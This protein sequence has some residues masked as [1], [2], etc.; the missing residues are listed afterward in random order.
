MSAEQRTEKKRVERL[1]KRLLSVVSLGPAIHC[2][3]ASARQVEQLLRDIQTDIRAII[4]EEF[5]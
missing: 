3:P 2:F 1:R 5:P 4:R